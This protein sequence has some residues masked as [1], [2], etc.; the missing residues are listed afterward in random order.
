MKPKS[1]TLFHFTKNIDIIKDILKNG[2]WPKYCLE[3]SRWYTLDKRDLYIAWPII[4]FCDI[5]LSRVDEHVNFYGNYGI[6][7]SKEWAQSNGLSPVLYIRENSLQHESLQQLCNENRIKPFYD[8]SN[9]HINT[10]LG[11]IKPIEGT[12]FINNEFVS[13]EFYQENEWRYSAIDS[14]K[15]GLLR[16]WLNANEY[17]DE[18][19][20][21]AENAKT[22]IHSS[23]KVSPCD[24][25]Y[26]FV[27]SDSDIPPLVNFIQTDLDMYPS[28]DIKI[29][30]SR[31]ISLE[32]ISRDM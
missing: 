26:I 1:H 11:H 25:R 19:I 23:I 15:I 3:H 21:S 8:K 7:V 20:L 14:S 18:A 2:F 13:K 30:L 4:C 32:T 27:K 9:L 29:L 6:G 31:I 12:M 22:K 28:H 24:I 5:P 16:P 17:T 10:L